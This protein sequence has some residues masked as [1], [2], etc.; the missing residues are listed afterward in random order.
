MMSTEHP[1]VASNESWI[2]FFRRTKRF[3][4]LILLA[5]GVVEFDTNEIVSQQYGLHYTDEK[6]D[7]L[8]RELTFDKKLNILRKLN[9]ISKEDYKVVLRFQNYRNK[10][11]HGD[12]EAWAFFLMSDAEKEPIIENAVQVLDI[13]QSIGFGTR[14]PK[15]VKAT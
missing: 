3:S 2:G 13:L 7:P 10:L 4:D 11:F 12:E 9:V 14:Y 15:K 6:A 8:L 1:D 5:W